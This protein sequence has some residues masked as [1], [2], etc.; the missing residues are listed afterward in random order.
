MTK[1]RGNR[2][3][4]KRH[5][6]LINDSTESRS[7]PTRIPYPRTPCGNS[8]PVIRTGPRNPLE[9]QLFRGADATRLVLA[10]AQDRA[11]WY[12]FRE[13]FPPSITKSLPPVQVYP[14]LIV[15]DAWLRLPLFVSPYTMTSP[16]LVTNATGALFKLPPN[17][18]SQ[19]PTLI[20]Q[21]R[22]ALDSRL[23]QPPGHQSDQI[24]RRRRTA[25]TQTNHLCCLRN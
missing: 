11:S 12:H 8:Y 9:K 7:Y 22:C 3:I 1:C 25:Q 15:Q 2:H 21:E 24:Q 23:S 19:I 13:R 10:Q 16:E 5:D 6:Y 18:P 14:L 17:H 4:I 20:R